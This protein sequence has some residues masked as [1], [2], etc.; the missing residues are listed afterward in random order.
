M[1]HQKGN[2]KRLESGQEML[3]QIFSKAKISPVGPVRTKEDDTRRNGDTLKYQKMKIELHH[4]HFNRQWSKM[5]TH[6]MV[7]MNINLDSDG[8]TVG[9]LRTALKRILVQYHH[10]WFISAENHSLY[11]MDYRIGPK[12][13]SVRHR[14]KVHD[15]LN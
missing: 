7:L 14:S 6:E 3:K 9:R 10:P 5:G 15:C 1:A 12:L 13:V 2:E 8:P 4:K 11:F